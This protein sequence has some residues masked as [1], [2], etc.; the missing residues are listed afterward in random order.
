[1]IGTLYFL[2]AGRLVE[3]WGDERRYRWVIKCELLFIANLISLLTM[4]SVRPTG[5]SISLILW[6]IL[7]GIPTAIWVCCSLTG[8]HAFLNS[9]YSHGPVANVT[10][11]EGNTVYIFSL[12]LSLPTHH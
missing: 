11:I 1:M 12:S 8:L 9:N 7:V 2:F 5:W 3:A 10:D 4:V 6:T